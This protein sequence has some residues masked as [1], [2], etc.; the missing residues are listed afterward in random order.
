VWLPCIST[1]SPITISTDRKFG[2]GI[3]RLAFHRDKRGLAILPQRKLS[4]HAWHSWGIL[5]DRLPYEGARWWRP[6]LSP[7]WIRVIRPL[8]LRRQRR[9]EGLQEVTVEG[10]E[11]LQSAVAQGQ[12]VLITPNHAGHVDAY[13]M[14]VAADQLGR[15]CYYMVAWQVLQLFSLAGR[16]LLQ[17]HGCFS[18]D[19]EGHDMRAFRKGVE[20]LTNSPHPLVIFAEGEVYH[21]CDRLAP[22]RE[23]AAAIALAA[24]QRARR[25][26]VCIP[27]AIRYQYVEDPTPQLNRHM[28]AL[29]RQLL[30]RPRPELP[31][32]ERLRSFA[33]ALLILREQYYLGHMQS[34]N[35]A[36]RIQTLMEAL[37]EPLEKRH[38]LHTLPPGSE[39]RGTDIPGRVSVLRHQVIQQM[40]GLPLHDAR[41]QTAQNELEDLDLVV[42]LFSYQHDFASEQPRIERLAEIVDKFEEDILGAPTASIHGKRR[43]T[44]RFGKPV[45]VKK[46]RGNRGAVRQLTATLEQ[47]VEALLL[48]LKSGEQQVMTKSDGRRPETSPRCARSEAAR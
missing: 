44:I 16:W 19:R 45:A 33:E 26:V 8:R 11:H 2:I 37:L 12:G 41:R 6:R 9:R 5:M 25:P 4:D 10:L 23:G 39:G 22:F 13:I 34:G 24:A 42:Q 15:P 29:E 43:A 38:G 20:I 31:L 14:L 3:A 17:R 27:A 47:E 30:W 7:F 21:N 46:E 28:E 18:V 32:A 1:G 35:Y 40:K 48:Q 36:S